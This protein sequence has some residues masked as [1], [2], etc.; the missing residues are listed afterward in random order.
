MRILIVEDSERMRSLLQ[1]GLTAQGLVVDAAVDG[2]DALAYLE[3]YPY[4]VVV[5]DLMMPR[6]D[7]WKVLQHIRSARLQTRVLVLSAM[8]QVEDRVRA[9]DLGADDFLIK[10]FSFD[11]VRARIQ[12]LGRRDQERPATE[13]T[14]GTVII[15]TVTKTVRVGG[16]RLALTPKEYALL[17]LLARRRGQVLSR[18]AIFEHLYASHSEASDK[19]IEVLMSTLRAKLAGAGAGELIETRR[20]FGYVLA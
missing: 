20:G 18:A 17:E 6:V 15:D 13:L 10:P 8:D 9:L 7:G 12:A 2:Q 4:D 19:V 1:T 11:E 14:A 5:L 3:R 16:A